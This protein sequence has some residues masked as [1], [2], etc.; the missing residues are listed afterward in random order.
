MHLFYTP[1]IQNIEFFQLTEEESKHAVRVLRLEINDEVW[2]TDGK[3]NLMKAIIL[4]NHP[5]RCT[6]QILHRFEKYGKRNYRLHLAVAPT[7]NIERFEWFLEKAT[8]IGVD[9]ITPILC[10]HSERTSIKSDRL[11]K[12]ISAAMK[13][14]LKAYHPIL[15][16]MM[17]FADVLKHVTASAKLMAWCEA[18]ADERIE[19]FVKP[20]EDALIFIGPE[21]GFSQKE[22]EMAKLAHTHLVSISSSRLRT[23]TAALVACHSI[24]FLNKK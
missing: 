6:L 22:I 2:L 3:G 20:T 18:P 8:E 21:G 7:K 19:N 14:S 23:E 16:P 9:E 12:V 11:E 4:E 13:Q 1:D 17:K 15:N 5:K 10:E 24:A